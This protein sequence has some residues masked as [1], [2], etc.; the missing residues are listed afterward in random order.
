[1]VEAREK[2]FNYFSQAFVYLI[3]ILITIF[4]INEVESYF[5]LEIE[6]F[7]TTTAFYL[8]LLCLKI[9]FFG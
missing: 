3:C 5:V 9:I 1:M 7:N 4:E 8:L 2:I 6:Y